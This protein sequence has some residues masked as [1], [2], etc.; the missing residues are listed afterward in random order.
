MINTQ[1]KQ[2]INLPWRQVCM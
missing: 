1:S 2:S